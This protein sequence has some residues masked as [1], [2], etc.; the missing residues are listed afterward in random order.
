MG[1]LPAVL[2]VGHAIGCVEEWKNLFESRPIMIKAI[3]Q[4]GLILNGGINLNGE[5]RIFFWLAKW[6]E[7]TKLY[8]EIT[9]E[10]LWD[11]AWESFDK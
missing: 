1:I 6:M 3:L 10:E 7:Y 8:L 9:A 4:G 5:G 11:Q 2:N